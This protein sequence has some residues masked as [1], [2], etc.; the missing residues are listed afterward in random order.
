[1][2]KNL[3]RIAVLTMVITMLS[4]LIMVKADEV[5]VEYW[6]DIIFIE[7][8]MNEL[9]NENPE[10]DDERL[11]ELLIVYLK[12]EEFVQ[13]KYYSGLVTFSY[14]P[15]KYQ[16]LNSEEKKLAVAHPL[17]AAKVYNASQKAESETKKHWG[18]NGLNDNSDAFRHCIWNMFM[19]IDIGAVAAEKWATAHEYNSS[20]SLEKTMDLYNNRIGRL[21]TPT[22][23]D[24]YTS[25]PIMLLPELA[26]Q[27]S[28]SLTKNG[29]LRRIVNGKIVA[30]NSVK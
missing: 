10:I 11:N 5:E 24:V 15:Q 3:I 12:S 17:Q 13:D 25:Y 21:N 19:T 18:R 29:S 16:A 4:R 28:L 30:T 23:Q 9:L 7:N 6:E 27:R 14:L 8:K 26:V 2:K 1:M 20:N 22:P